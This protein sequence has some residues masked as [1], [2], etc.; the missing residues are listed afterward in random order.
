M[1]P[2]ANTP[3]SRITLL[4]EWGTAEA[5]DRLDQLAGESDLLLKAEPRPAGVT[6]DLAGITSLD[7]CGCQLLAVFLGNLKR[8]G[9]TSELWGTP[10]GICQEIRLLGFQESL[11]LAEVPEKENS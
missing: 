4:G 3:K 2:D 8:H 5:L 6:I 11:G 1:L 10:A 7:A 9:L